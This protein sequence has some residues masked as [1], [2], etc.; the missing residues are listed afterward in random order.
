M[1]RAWDQKRQITQRLGK[2]GTKLAVYSGKGGVGKTTVAV[3]L[4]VALAQ[5]AIS[6][7]TVRDPAVLDVL[8]VA[9]AAAGRFAEA[10][11]AAEAALAEHPAPVFA[12]EIRA[13]LER[14]RRAEPYR[15]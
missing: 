11:A 7:S 15:P 6:Q 2:I 13:R 4:A 5:R 9:Y 12:G 1:K 10:I 8:G 3:N 14:Y